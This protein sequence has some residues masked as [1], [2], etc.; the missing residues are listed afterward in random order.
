[1][2]G[3]LKAMLLVHVMI[4]DSTEQSVQVITDTTRLEITM[5][6]ESL[7]DEGHSSTGRGCLGCQFW[8][9]TKLFSSA[10]LAPSL[11]KEHQ[12]IFLC[13]RIFVSTCDLL[14]SVF[15]R[16]LVLYHRDMTISE[17]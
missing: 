5:Q 7:L 11:S 8:D 9:R 10:H 2:Q 14:I 4:S 3:R 13:H 17:P 6:T 15:S 16:T 1:M 12:E